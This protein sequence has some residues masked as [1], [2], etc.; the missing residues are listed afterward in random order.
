MSAVASSLSTISAD[1]ITK[2][3]SKRLSTLLQRNPKNTDWKGIK[4]ILLTYH[5]NKKDAPNLNCLLHLALNRACLD[6]SGV[7]PGTLKIILEKTKELS[8]SERI[9]CASM[10]VR[11]QNRK[12]LQALID[13]DI[14]VLFY[15]S[16][17]DDDNDNTLVTSNVRGITLLHMVCEEHGWN[18]EIAFILDEILKNNKQYN[19]DVTNSD[20]SNYHEG[21]FQETVESEIPLKLSLQAGSGLEEVLDHVREKHPD[22]LESNLDRLCQIVAEYCYDMTLLSD[23]ID[24]YGFRLLDSFHPKDGSSP[25]GFACYYQNEDMIRVLLDAYYGNNNTKDEATSDKNNRKSLIRVQKRLLSPNGEGMSPLGHLLLSVSDPDAENTWRCINACVRFFINN[26]TDNGNDNNNEEGDRIPRSQQQQFP[27][28]HF[29]LL[30]TWDAL[31]AKKNCMKILDRIIQRLGVNVCLVD[32]ETGSTML[33]IVIVKLSVH[34]QAKYSKKTHAMALRILD[35]LTINNPAVTGNSTT[36]HRPAITRDG[37]G[38]LPLHLACEHS[39]PWKTGLR[40]IVDAFVP[41]L[42][43]IDPITRLPAFA[44]CAVGPKSDLDSIYELFRINPGIIDIVLPI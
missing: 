31:I 11:C 7:S 17:G 12:A 40:S 6:P 3:N 8:L 19:G 9:R 32:D 30:H 26:D 1:Q 41:A 23:L 2:S 21:L 4:A 37:T 27:I 38:R 25:L 5:P 18:D 15:C 39:L 35:Y 10:A 20:S 24:A 28:L 33:S 16:G 14:S 22:Y 44:H 29:F 36:T 42:E 43:S 13:N 34:C